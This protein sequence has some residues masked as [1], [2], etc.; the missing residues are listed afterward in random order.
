MLPLSPKW[1]EI[2]KMAFCLF[3]IALRLKTV[4]YKVA[5]CSVTAIKQHGNFFLAS[6]Y[7]CM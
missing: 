4:C 2:F 5:L 1:A 7:V 6:V 3:K